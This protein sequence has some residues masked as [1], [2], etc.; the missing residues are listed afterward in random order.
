MRKPDANGR[1]MGERMMG[2]AKHFLGDQISARRHLEYALTLFEPTD[3]GRGVARFATDS[4]VI[5]RVFY[6]SS[7]FGVGSDSQSRG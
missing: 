1:V 5:V 3:H 2:A 4:W 7:L 6:A